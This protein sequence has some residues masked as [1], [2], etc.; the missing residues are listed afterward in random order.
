MRPRMRC[1]K[2]NDVQAEHVDELRLSRDLGGAGTVDDALAETLSE[3]AGIDDRRPESVAA[4]VHSWTGHG[5][6][7]ES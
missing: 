5:S 7:D 4:V 6:T 1:P 2:V 3:D